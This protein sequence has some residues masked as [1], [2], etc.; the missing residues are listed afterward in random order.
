[1]VDM[2]DR[3]EELKEVLST[4]EALAIICYNKYHHKGFINCTRVS[5]MIK[6]PI[7]KVKD[8]CVKLEEMKVLKIHRTGYDMEVEMLDQD[9]THTKHII[10][11]VIWENKQEYGKIYKKLITA[12]LVDFMNYMK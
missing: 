11:E 9:D 10:D 8:T 4:N 5:E 2:G 3:Y 6:V 7:N 1:V 12:E